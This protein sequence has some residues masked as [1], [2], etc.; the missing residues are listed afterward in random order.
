MRRD[1]IE[2]KDRMGVLFDSSS[3]RFEGPIPPIPP[4]VHVL[5]REHTELTLRD[6]FG[7]IWVQPLF[8]G[9]PVAGC[10]LV[11]CADIGQRRTGFPSAGPVYLLPQQFFRWSTAIRTA[12]CL[13]RALMASYPDRTMARTMAGSLRSMREAN[14][15]E[16]GCQLCDGGELK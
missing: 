9:K 4:H 7:F 8:P 1:A 13:L 6:I 3:V 14:E 10:L 16:M 2:T 12:G 15:G 11:H 5:K